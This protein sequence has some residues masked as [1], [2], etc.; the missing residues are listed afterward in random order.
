ML[1]ASSTVLLLYTLLTS[2]LTSSQI[3]SIFVKK[4]NWGTPKKEVYSFWA[5]AD[6][7][8]VIRS[9][10]CILI[11]YMYVHLLLPKIVFYLNDLVINFESILTSF[12]NKT[13]DFFKFFNNV[14]WQKAQVTS[15]K[16]ENDHVYWIREVFVCLSN[17]DFLPKTYIYL[18]YNM[19]F[20]NA[21]IHYVNSL[22]YVYFVLSSQEFDSYS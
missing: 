3:S 22:G 19:I 8:H 21:S 15:V 10:L 13:F 5:L 17:V 14:L 11:W 4:T 6:M 9:H 16:D 20:I 18:E 12:N 2:S 7:I 1:T